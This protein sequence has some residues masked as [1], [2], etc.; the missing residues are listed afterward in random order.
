MV[1]GWSVAVA[2]GR[3]VDVS[4]GAGVSVGK[5][6]AVE[7]GASVGVGRA[8]RFPPQ[9]DRR[10]TNIKIHEAKGSSRFIVSFYE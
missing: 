4:V 8:P 1:S 10:N 9:A 7:T 3:G 5:K 2:V 6:V